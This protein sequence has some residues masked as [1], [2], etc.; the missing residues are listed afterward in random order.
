MY[1]V[2]LLAGKRID[3]NDQT[4]AKTYVRT[5]LELKEMSERTFFADCGGAVSRVC[6]GYPSVKS[7]DVGGS[8]FDLHQ[9]HG[10]E[11]WRVLDTAICSH[12]AALISRNLA[13][14]SI[15]M[16]TVAP[17]LTQ[18]LQTVG[19]GAL[20][21]TSEAVEDPRAD[22][23][24]SRL[25]RSDR[26]AKVA[27]DIAKGRKRGRPPEKLEAAKQAMMQDLKS[28]LRTPEDLRDMFGKKL[29]EVYG[30]CRTTASAARNAVLSEFVEK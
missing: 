22:G 16:M 1:K 30:L 2:E 14:T 6:A 27:P 15:L 10:C 20:A 9:R 4:I 17:G 24:T 8:V 26:T 21:E 19:K 7:D 12:S 18:P 5:A 28:G 11:I 3:R 29:A 23:P 13:P 25:A